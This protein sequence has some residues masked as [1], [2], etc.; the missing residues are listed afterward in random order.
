LGEKEPCEGDNAF[1]RKAHVLQ[2]GNVAESFTFSEDDLSAMGTESLKG[3]A[4]EEFFLKRFV[5]EAGGFP[6]IG[7][8]MGV[9]EGEEYNQSVVL[10]ILSKCDSTFV[11]IGTYACGAFYLISAP[12]LRV[13]TIHGDFTRADGAFVLARHDSFVGS[14]HTHSSIRPS[15]FNFFMTPCLYNGRTLT[16]ATSQHEKIEVCA[17]YI[18]K[19]VIP[20]PAYITP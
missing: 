19:T 3:I 12:Y 15:P 4:V 16:A 11:R 6:M 2:F 14:R 10:R 7:A 8:F 1:R 17:P 13:F 18:R 20:V 5:I 9:F